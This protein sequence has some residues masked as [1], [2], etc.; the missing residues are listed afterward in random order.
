MIGYTIL[1]E[2]ISP[3]AAVVRTTLK[4]E[5]KWKYKFSYLFYTSILFIIYNTSF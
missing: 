1:V 3:G 2:G 5:V 4:S